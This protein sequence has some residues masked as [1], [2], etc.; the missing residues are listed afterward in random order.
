MCTD[1]EDF[2]PGVFGEPEPVASKMR[3]DAIARRVEAES[4]HVSA[5]TAAV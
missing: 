1:A 3:V 5:L 2:F 4:G